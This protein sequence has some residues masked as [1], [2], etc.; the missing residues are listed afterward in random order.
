MGDKAC[1]F[2]APVTSHSNSASGNNSPID[3]SAPRSR[4]STLV[5]KFESTDGGKGGMQA[6]GNGYHYRHFSVSR[7]SSLSGSSGSSTEVTKGFYCKSAPPHV[8]KYLNNYV[9]I[10]NSVLPCYP[11]PFHNARP[12]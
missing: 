1:T 12:M 9:I 10:S 11:L 7:S 6:S 5:S 3:M 2:E 8:R 4:V